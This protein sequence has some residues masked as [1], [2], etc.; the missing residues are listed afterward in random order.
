MKKI[1]SNYNILP[2]DKEEKDLQSVSNVIK[3]PVY[4]KDDKKIDHN[5]TNYKLKEPVLQLTRNIEG[6]VVGVEV[7]CTCG[8]KILIKM[9]YK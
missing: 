4:Q 3:I 8:E 6:V 9:D 1:I 2:D 7:S 5:E